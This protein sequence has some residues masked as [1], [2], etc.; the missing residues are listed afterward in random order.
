MVLD[1]V[2]GFVSA[3]GTRQN[4][5]T[6]A[7]V[8]M[9]LYM[10]DERANAADKERVVAALSAIRRNATVTD[11]VVQLMDSQIRERLGQISDPTVAASLRRVMITGQ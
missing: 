9:L 3:P 4:A 1:E 5:S 6:A 11:P 7:I 10:L 2:E 8:G